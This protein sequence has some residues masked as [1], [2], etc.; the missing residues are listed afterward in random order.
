MGKRK[1][2]QSKR[3]WAATLRAGQA[4]LH[5]PCQE[6][7]AQLLDVVETAELLTANIRANQLCVHPRHVH[8]VIA[9]VLVRVI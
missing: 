4:R 5:R 3:A 1:I 7:D 9:I 2:P 6:S 8:L